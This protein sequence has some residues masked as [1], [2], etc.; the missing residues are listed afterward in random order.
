MMKPLIQLIAKQA[1]FSLDKI[2]FKYCA[3]ETNLLYHIT[4]KG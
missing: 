3:I 2:T 4:N 1:C